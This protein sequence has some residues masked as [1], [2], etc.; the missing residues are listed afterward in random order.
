MTSGTLTLPEGRAGQAL[1]IAVT[2]IVA[3]AIWLGVVMPLLGWYAGQSDALATAQL[4][5]AHLQA[6]QASLPELRR[7]IAET[8][9][10]SSAAEVLLQGGSDAIAGANLQAALNTLATQAGASLD[11]T[12]S[13]PAEAS[14]GLRRIGVAV[15]L[16][17]T[18]PT[19][20]AFLT[21]IDLASPRM[22]V[23]DL[24]V[25]ADSE[26]DSRQDVSLQASF[27]VAAFRAGAGP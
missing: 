4:E 1:A 9:I 15:S 23:S 20:V 22:I 6:L 18:W 2:I 3:A 8:A 16:T 25:S 17:A 26:P 5:A 12:E 7:R 27:M 14:G 10:Q 11:S 24:T 19:L 13:I 21:A